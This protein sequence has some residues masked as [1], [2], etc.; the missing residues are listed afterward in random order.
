MKSRCTNTRGSARLAASTL[1]KTPSSAERRAASVVTPRCRPTYHSGRADLAAGAAGR[2][3]QHAGSARLLPAHERRG[4]VGEEPVNLL[5]CAAGR[6]TGRCPGRSRRG[7]RAQV[8]R[9][10]L[11]SVQ[12]CLRSSPATRTKAAEF[13]VGR[14]VHRDERAGASGNTGNSGGSS[15]RWRRARLERRRA[16]PRAATLRARKDVVHWGKLDDSSIRAATP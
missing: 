15:R 11:G 5:A 3:R 10:H 9:D 7:S 14:R 13:R 2:I 12:P 6:D 4:G 16:A 8:L 1:R